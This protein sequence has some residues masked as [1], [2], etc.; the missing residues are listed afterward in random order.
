MDTKA[1]IRVK[2]VD[3]SARPGYSPWAIQCPGNQAKWGRCVYDADPFSRDYDWLVVKN[4][5]PKILGCKE[6]LSCPGSALSFSRPNPLPS[7]AMAMPSL[8]SSGKC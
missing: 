2:L 1:Q 8:P 4:D 7:R 6:V 5:I 3:R